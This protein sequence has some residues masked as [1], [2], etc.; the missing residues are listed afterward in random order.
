MLVLKKINQA[1]R[2]SAKIITRS[3]SQLIDELRFRQTAHKIDFAAPRVY[4]GRVINSSVGGASVK[5]HRLS[6]YFPHYNYGYNL[7]YTV[8][9]SVSASACR[10][11]KRY[12]VNVVYNADGV[13]YGAYHPEKK[14]KTINDQY[15]RVYEQADHVFFQSRFAQMSA[16][17][18]LG[19]PRAAHEILYN[20]VDTNFFAPGSRPHSISGPTLLTAGFHRMF[21][22]LEVVV[23]AVDVIRK[24]YPEVHLIIA[25]KLGTGTGIW[26]VDGPIQALIEELGLT[27]HVTFL[28][29]YSQAEA[30]NIY[31]LGDVLVHA[32]WNDVCPSVVI[33]AM[34][35]GL[36]VVYSD[37]GGTPELVGDAGLGVSSPKVLNWNELPVPSYQEFAEKALLVLA[38]RYEMSKIAR[39]RAEQFF[40][41]RYWIK[42]HFE[43]FE[44][45]LSDRSNPN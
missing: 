18:F 20:A 27:E 12:G 14:W 31:R 1:G 35:C 21:Y 8:N 45:L 26:D 30:P 28:P 34:S 6:K 3:I 11:A 40:D 5:A 9:G 24:E 13:L 43:L 17:H 42:R 41:I 19:K 4:Y 23:R 38:N 16:E 29:V 15:R 10:R 36:P 33:E 39:S 22:R 44:R 32:Q 25:G 37:S 2:R 7:I